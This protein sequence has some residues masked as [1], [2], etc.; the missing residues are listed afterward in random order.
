MST[1]STHLREYETLYVLKPEIHDAAAKEI[2][3]KYKELVEKNGGT[4]IKVT[5]WGRRKLAWER[6]RHQRGLFVHHLY[7]GQPGLVEAFERALQID[8]S[9]LLRTT[10][11][12][13]KK[14][15]AADR[16][17]EE[18]ELEPPVIK[19]RKEEPR[20]DRDDDRGGYGGGRGG[21][22]GGGDR[23]GFGG[24]DRGGYRGDR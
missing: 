1:L 20:R 2:M 18:D 3:L 11:V 4:T 24:G 8:E 5:N 9:A 19:E 21:F 13:S 17:V 15:I 10:V 12:I 16:K 7:L 14:V 23:G 22:G 6:D